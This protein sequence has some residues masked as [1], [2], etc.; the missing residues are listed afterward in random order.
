MDAAEAA[1][2]WVEHGYAFLPGYLTAG[3]IAAARAE[4]HDTF[5]T[6][7]EFHDDVDPARNDRFRGD[8]FGGIDSFPFGGMEL[9]LLAGHPKLVAFAGAILETDDVRLYGCETWAKYAGAA[10]YEQEHHRDL[11]GHS[12]LAPS[13]APAF[14]QVEM[15]V[16][17]DDVTER[18]A[19]TRYVPRT[20]T[21][22]LPLVPRKRSRAE[23]PELYDAEVSFPG[24]A[25]SVVAWSVDTFHRAVALTDPRGARFTLQ[26]N[27][28]SGAAEWMTR[29]AWGYVSNTGEWHRFVERASFRHLLLVGFPPPGHAYWTPETLALTRE[30]Y[31]GLDL[32]PWS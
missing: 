31:P 12:P 17:L 29:I 15:F 30:R 13:R 11:G 20:L 28:R 18:C 3:E 24:P 9:C 21:D 5:P 10:D 32:S 16:Y 6:A 7:S 26:A 4:L 14:R 22:H 1:A 25:G 19:P 2:H 27:F 8:Q 23:N